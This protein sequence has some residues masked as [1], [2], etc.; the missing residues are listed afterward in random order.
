MSYVVPLK[1]SDEPRP[2]IERLDA[3]L[4]NLEGLFRQQRLTLDVAILF[5]VPD[6]AEQPLTK[7]DLLVPFEASSRDFVDIRKNYPIAA[8]PA[9]GWTTDLAEVAGGRLTYGEPPNDVDVMQLA[10]R[11]ELE[12]VAGSSVASSADDGTVRES[13]S[14]RDA[15]WSRVTV[16]FDPQEPGTHGY[17]RFRLHIFGR[18]GAVLWKR[19]GMAVNGAL[20]DLK[21]FV[22][23]SA[24]QRIQSW[25]RP[26]RDGLQLVRSSTTLVLRASLQPKST[27]P[28]AEPQ[29]L[30]YGWS[31]YLGRQTD[32][33]DDGALIAYTSTND[34]NRGE[35][36]DSALFMDV[37][38]EFGLLPLG[39]FVRIAVIGVLIVLVFQMMGVVPPGERNLASWT[40]DRFTG[41]AQVFWTA[42]VIAGGLALSFLTRLSAVRR[43]LRRAA[44]WYA[45]KELKLLRWRAP[46]NKG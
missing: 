33:R 27:F 34:G 24:E 31:E 35:D 15:R 21:T 6:N 12:L 13:R 42:G 43:Q 37:S 5:G 3:T 25:A 11:M 2:I 45:R 17:I 32:L 4:W 46:W 26:E 23:D 36:H 28:E 7:I 19:S 20:F 22:P 41:A 30:E 9:P 8:F 1:S 44:N 29:F 38:R 40:K 16:A 10:V 14:R 39:N 18:C